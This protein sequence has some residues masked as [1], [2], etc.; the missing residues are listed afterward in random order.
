M[1]ARENSCGPGGTAVG[2]GPLQGNRRSQ[3][4]YFLGSREQGCFVEEA[5]GLCTEYWNR[6]DKGTSVRAQA[7]L[8]HC[9]VPGPGLPSR[10]QEGPGVE[11]PISHLE[12]CTLAPASKV[13]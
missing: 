8:R 2:P 1:I 3:R 10:P 9:A 12:L 13:S 5:W 4:K 6:A 11:S 7:S